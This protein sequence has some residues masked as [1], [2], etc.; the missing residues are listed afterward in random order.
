MGKVKEVLKGLQKW[1]GK[2][3]ILLAIGMV[4]QA[5]KAK[6]PDWPLPSED[7]TRDTFLAVVGAHTATDLV[8]VFKT[9]G[10]EVLAGNA[11]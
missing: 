6:Y 7:F 11:K 3:V 9:A 4:L 5:L 1:A 8:H 10:K 2:K